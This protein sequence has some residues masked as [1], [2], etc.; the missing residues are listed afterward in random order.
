MRN[1]ARQETYFLWAI[2]IL[3]VV[4]RL[5][6]LLFFDNVFSHEGESYSKINLVQT[7]IFHGRPYPDVN[8][9]PLHTW[10]IYLLVSIF[11]DWIW[12]VR[13]FG[14][15]AGS[16]TVPLFYVLAK[17]EFGP[18]TAR[19]AALL[20][21]S[22]P[23]HLRAS[24]TG[25][26]EVPYLLFFVAGL[27]CFFRAAIRRKRPWLWLV[28]AAAGITGAGMLRFE[29][30]LFLPVLCLLM[31]RRKFSMAVVFGAL[32]AVFPLVHMYI[33][34]KTTG[35][36][37]NFAKT[38]ALSFLQYMPELPMREKAVGWFVS[39][40]RGMGP[41]AAI[42]S[43]VGIIYALVNGR[44]WTFAV[45]A[46]FPLAI[47]QYKAMTNT[48]DPSLERYIVSMATLAFPYAALVLDKTGVWLDHRRK[49]WG[50]LVMIVV[51]AIMV[52]QFGW[53]WNHAAQ[54][55]YPGD[56]K[57]MVNWLKQNAGED[58]HVLPDQRFHPY[59]QL[60]SRLPYDSFVNLEWTAD[61]KQLNENSYTRLLRQSPPTI[62][63]LDYLLAEDPDNM[64][65]SNLDVFHIAKGRPQAQMR[66][67]DF[68][69]AFEQGNFV[70]YR[71]TK[72]DAGQ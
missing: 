13:I 61:R 8:F 4:S 70:I 10:L 20:F 67:L 69:L 33:C 7:W 49:G 36:P 40:W 15:L 19:L 24:P 42:L 30:W 54:N 2:T 72:T 27:I 55:K 34:Y 23:V 3:A 51:V 6:F 41:P 9:G 25:L 48:M 39:F 44:K 16:L 46:M 65:N 26:A 53:G 50:M 17:E 22:F 5:V 1:H 32:C 37:T 57:A 66:G 60:E 21:L 47:V 62:V 45:L 64:V 31:W 11:H 12:P 14:L 63:I 52:F 71:T 58:D 29:A 59:V 56:I 28:L 18:Q 43:V 68:S 38:S 35:D